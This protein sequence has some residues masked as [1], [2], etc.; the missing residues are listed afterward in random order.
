M[1]VRAAP[2]SRARRRV[3]LALLSGTVLPAPV[4]AA[5]EETL[6]EVVAAAVRSRGHACE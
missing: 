6:T 2:G 5:G 3:A 1:S 4:S